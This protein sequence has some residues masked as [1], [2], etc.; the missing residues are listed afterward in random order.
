MKLEK[1]IKYYEK[2]YQ[3]KID[4]EI[5]DDFCL[6][7]CYHNERDFTKSTILISK[8]QIKNLD[9]SHR[10]KYTNLYEKI[11]IVLLHEI[12][13]SIQYNRD[14]QIFID[15][16]NIQGNIEHNKREYEIQADI[17]AR[18]EFKKWKK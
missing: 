5:I 17:F 8:E 1:I 10:F 9:F 2:K 6:S 12:G 11:I 14:R 13:H 18:A 15:T 4:F 3:I 7:Q 16:H